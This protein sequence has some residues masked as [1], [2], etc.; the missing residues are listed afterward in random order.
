MTANILVI[1]DDPGVRE[2][3]KELLQVEGYQVETVSS[4]EEGLTAVRTGDYDLA[5]VDI[6]LPGLDGAVVMEEIRKQR[7]DTQVIIISGYGSLES[8]IL[9]LR[10]GVK[11]YFIKPYPVEELLDAICRVLS[12]KENRA[13]KEIL[14]EQ[15]ES[16]LEQLKDLEGIQTETLPPRRVVTLPGGIMVDLERRELWRGN[17]RVNLTP[18]ESNLLGNFLENKGRVMTHVEL[19]LL[20]QG[21]QVDEDEAPEILRPMVSRLRKKLSAF[22][23]TDNW[24]SNVRGTGYSFDPS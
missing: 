24:I 20:V 9:A 18:T 2:S 22:P 19:V 10:L 17:E 6:R 23:G 11:D 21:I 15:L 12:E 1:D 7:P 16:S 3:L 5:L 13:R 14:L 8:A 4:G